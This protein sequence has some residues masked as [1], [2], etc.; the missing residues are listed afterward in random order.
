[1]HERLDRI[2]LS[3]GKLGRIV[4]ANARTRQDR[5]DP[6]AAARQRCAGRARL[7]RTELGEPSLC[8]GARIMILGLP[9]T[10]QPQ[11]CR[12][13]TQNSGAGKPAGAE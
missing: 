9:V 1:V 4:G 3:A 10:Q 5:V 12:H 7:T 2:Q 8:I 13:G 6:N 11:M